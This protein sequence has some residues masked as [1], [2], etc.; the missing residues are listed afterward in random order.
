MRDEVQRGAEASL[1]TSM[2]P[3]AAHTGREITFDDKL[4]CDHELAPGLDQLSD[5]PAPVQ[6]DAKGRYPGPQP[7]LS[8]CALRCL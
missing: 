8:D 5:S 3:M 1:V 2:G 4:G 7:C 6:P